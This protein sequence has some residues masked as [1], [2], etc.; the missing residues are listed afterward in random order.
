MCGNSFADI[1]VAG[2]EVEEEDGGREVVLWIGR[3]VEGRL[4]TDLVGNEGIDVL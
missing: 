2:E 4:V 3:I 1:G